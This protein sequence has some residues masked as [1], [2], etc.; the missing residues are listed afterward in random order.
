MKKL[1]ALIL[2]MTLLTSTFSFAN[3]SANEE[4]QTKT[5][6]ENNNVNLSSDSGISGLLQNAIEQE[7]NADEED[8]ANQILDVSVEN[9]IATVSFNNNVKCKLIVAIYDEV[10]GDMAGSGIET[11]EK[12]A[13]KADITLDVAVMPEYFTVKVFILDEDNKPL[14]KSYESIYYTKAHQEFLEKTTDDFDSENVLNLDSDKTNNFA[15]FD[16]DTKQIE[17]TEKNKLESKNDETKTYTFSNIDTEISSLQEGD[18]FYY[19][20]NDEYIIV[21]VKTITINGTNA[22]IVGEQDVELDDIFSFVK[23][24]TESNGEGATVDASDADEGVTYEGVAE[25]QYLNQ[26]QRASIDI[27]TSVTQKYKIEKELKSKDESKKV[28]FVGSLALSIGVSLK[29]ELYL[30]YFSVEIKISPELTASIGVKGSITSAKIHLGSIKVPLGPTGLTAGVDMDFL[31]EA[32][33]E[34]SFRVKQTFAVGFGFDTKQGF[35]NKSEPAK[36][37]SEFN[38]EGKFFVGIKLSPNVELF[39]GVVKISLNGSGGLEIKGENFKK[40]EL[41]ENVEKHNCEFCIDGSLKF[42]MDLKVT[43]KVKLWFVKSETE[44]KIAS[45]EFKILDWYYNPEIRKFGKGDCPNSSYKAI[46]TIRNSKGEKL[47]EATVNGQK[48]DEKGKLSIFCSPND[49]DFEIKCEGYKTRQACYEIKPELNKFVVTLRTTTQSSGGDITDLGVADES[50]FNYVLYDYE[51]GTAIIAIITDYN[52]SASKLKIPSKLGGYPVTSIGDYAFYWRE[53]LT[54]VTI[55]DSVTSIGLDAFYG[56]ESLTSVTIGNSVTSIGSNAFY[57][58]ES[59]TSITIPDS[60]TSIGLDAFENC[61]SLTSVTIGNSVTSIGGGAFYNTG[62]YNNEDNWENNVLYIGNYLIEAETSI[63]GDYTIK[64]GTKVIAG[65]AFSDCTSLTSVTIPDSVTSIGSGA[66]NG[67]KSLTSI[68]IPNSVT[69]IGGDAFRSCTS[70]TSITIPDSVTSI[71]WNAFYGCT[72]LT[73]VYYSGTQEQWNRIDIGIYNSA[74]TSATIHYNSSGAKSKSLNSFKAKNYLANNGEAESDSSEAEYKTLSKTDLAPNQVYVLMIIAGSETDYEVNTSSLKYITDAVADENGNVDFK[75][76]YDGDEDVIAVVFGACNHIAGE[77]QIEE[78]SSCTADGE[79]VRYCT[80]CFEAL[81]IQTIPAAHIW[82]EDYTVDVEPT[83]NT[84]GSKSIHCSVCG[85]KK[86]GSEVI[87]PPIASTESTEPT[88]PTEPSEPIGPTMPTEPTTN[89]TNP[90][91]TTTS[92]EPIGPTKPAN[93]TT[94]VKAKN[95]TSVTSAG[96]TKAVEKSSLK[97]PGFKLLK[98][99]KQFKI[100]YKA[101]S[102]ANGFQVR[103]KIKGKWKTKTFKAKK[104]ATKLIKKLKRGTYKVQIRSFVKNGSEKLYSKWSK[105]KT[106]K[107]K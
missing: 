15:V 10:T 74:L 85:A 62:Y 17:E 38:F 23:I 40:S 105:T 100:N 41:D 72:S 60:V 13:E 8:I 26:K 32:S 50:D 58:C 53:S 12:D 107:V 20:Y 29:A 47:T 99:R 48:V 19:E 103:Y 87:L 64:D 11:V 55:P 79:K 83:E 1:L 27:G 28:S 56:C 88:E 5:T 37:T 24:D 70:L 73:D 68:A 89:I 36:T 7:N 25:P 84:E 18:D 57:G 61:T 22:T 42:K 96:P 98:G 93:T 69:S 94:T 63:S 97:V 9:Q 51:N 35:S 106:V 21:K 31:A 43:L 82:N 39:A 77:W 90:T 76:L 45:I 30:R 102:G 101:V 54:S 104:N 78:E 49:N 91:E 66:F 95:T 92:N 44:Y 65:N 71:G 3:V 2:C 81:E 46:F 34:I 67:C 59:L 16:D 6:L 14:N 75:Y 52:G 33:A 80:K 4:T 86:P